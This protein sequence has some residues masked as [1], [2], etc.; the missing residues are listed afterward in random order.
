[1]KEKGGTQ[2][3]DIA[4][5]AVERLELEGSAASLMKLEIINYHQPSKENSDEIIILRDKVG[6]YVK[7]EI[8]D[9]VAWGINGPYNTN[10]DNLGIELMKGRLELAR[11]R[12]LE[13]L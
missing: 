8:E 1:M 13:V 2:H 5:E 7:N 12:D 3:K 10:F 4:E 11:E 6:P 9:V